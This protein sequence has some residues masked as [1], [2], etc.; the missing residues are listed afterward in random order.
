MKLFHD[1]LAMLRGL[2]LN[3]FYKKD[4]NKKRNKKQI[5]VVE[6]L[7]ILLLLMKMVYLLF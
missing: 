4:K 5:D 3:V 1:F 6:Q 2:T 7:L